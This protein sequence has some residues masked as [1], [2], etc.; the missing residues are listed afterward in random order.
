MRDGSLDGSV[1]D[2]EILEQF[3]APVVA[4]AIV[5]APAVAHAAPATLWRVS[6]FTS[7]GVPYAT[8]SVLKVD[9]RGEDGAMLGESVK[10]D[11]R[12]AAASGTKVSGHG[13]RLDL[14]PKSPPLSVKAEYSLF[15]LGKASDVCGAAI[16]LK[17]DAPFCLKPAGTC[18][19]TSHKGRHSCCLG[20]SLLLRFTLPV[21]NEVALHP[22]MHSYLLKD[23]HAD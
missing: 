15:H 7:P 21:G 18:K 5:V 11:L 1:L 12:N 9:G 2:L 6:Q 17:M 22:Q 23:D 4:S 20:A 14:V 16:G 13:S 3:I 19:I 10:I 8:V